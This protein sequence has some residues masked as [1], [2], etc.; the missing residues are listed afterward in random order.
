MYNCV[1]QASAP[2]VFLSW[3]SWIVMITILCIGFWKR[4]PFVWS[5]DKNGLA[6]VVVT[7][8]HPIIWGYGQQPCNTPL[9]FSVLLFCAVFIVLWVWENWKEKVLSADGSIE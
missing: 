7:L 4:Y 3:S 1:A 9:H 6:G 8:F 2:V 5:R